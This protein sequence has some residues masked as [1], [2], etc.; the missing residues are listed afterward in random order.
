MPQSKLSEEERLERRRASRR[1]SYYKHQDEILAA[2]T[3]KRRANPEPNRAASRRKL[4][5]ETPDEREQRL[6]Y[7]KNWQVEHKAAQSEL[8]KAKRAEAALLKT[9]RPKLSKSEAKERQRESLKLFQ[10]RNREKL[11]LDTARRRAADPAKARAQW[12]AS[13]NKRRARKSGAALSDLHLIET[14][15]LNWKRKRS[16]GCYW[17]RQ[18]FSPKKCHTDHITPLKRGGA[19]AIDNLCISCGPCNRHK[20]A[21]TLTD[22]NTTIAEP[23]LL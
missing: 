16:V 1:K 10:K 7:L 5:N 17:C 19:H 6:A 22:W 3:I 20:S 15:E 9:P 8:A 11:R 13:V 12:I 4:A 18:P 23:V 14:W 21:K 2:K